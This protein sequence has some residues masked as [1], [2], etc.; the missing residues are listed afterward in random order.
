MSEGC[1]P[2]GGCASLD[3]MCTNTPAALLRVSSVDQR[4]ISAASA[5]DHARQHDHRQDAS[6][7]LD[8][9]PSCLSDKNTSLPQLVALLVRFLS[10]HAS[11]RA[12]ATAP[13]RNCSYSTSSAPWSPLRSR[14]AEANTTGF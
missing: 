8:T 11:P 9:R 2:C 12:C 5:T 4:V 13:S 6:W 3:V 1:L 7:R 10:A 14:P